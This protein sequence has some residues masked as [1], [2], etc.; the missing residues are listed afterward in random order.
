[1]CVGEPLQLSVPCSYRVKDLCTGSLLHC[2]DPGSAHL[3]SEPTTLPPIPGLLEVWGCGVQ[4]IPETPKCFLSP[5]SQ[6]PA[7]PLSYSCQGVGEASPLSLYGT[8]WG[9]LDFPE[10][11]IA[12][13]SWHPESVWSIDVTTDPHSPHHTQTRCSHD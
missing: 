7:P 10:D 6:L 12:Q 9:T 2:G 4:G 5:I 1:M 13:A 11:N 8:M 3:C